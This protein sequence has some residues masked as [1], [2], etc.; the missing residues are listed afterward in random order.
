MASTYPATDKQMAFLARLG[1]A[2]T[3][4]VRP[5]S[6]AASEL[7]DLALAMSMDVA[8]AALPVSR[9]MTEWETGQERAWTRADL[10]LFERLQERAS[11][12][13]CCED[14]DG[15][16]CCPPC[17]ARAQLV[18]EARR[19][20]VVAAPVAAR[21]T[22]PGMYRVGERILKVQRAKLSGNLY[23]KELSPIGGRR[24]TETDEVVGFEFVYAPGALAELSAADKLTLEEAKAFGI[25]TGVCCVCGTPLKDAVSVASG[26]GPICAKRMAA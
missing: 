10:D 17:R 8:P 18:D 21:V 25:Q 6:R 9:A 5:T 16:T 11:L 1:Y 24:L 4:D 20:S 3:T 22:E 15:E 26:I 19:G 23:A 12:D 7:I 2:R 14:Y 13:C